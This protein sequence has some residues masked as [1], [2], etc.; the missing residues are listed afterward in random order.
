MRLLVI[1]LLYACSTASVDT[2]PASAQ[3]EAAASP[4]R[5]KAL[6][7]DGW[8]A[9]DNALQTNCRIWPT[10]DDKYICLPSSASQ[11]Q[12]FVDGNCTQPVLAVGVNSCSRNPEFVYAFTSVLNEYPH[13]IYWRG[14]VSVW[15]PDMVIPQPA[16]LFISN[17][18]NCRKSSINAPIAA[19]FYAL[20]AA[21]TNNLVKLTE[22]LEH[23]DNDKIRRPVISDGKTEFRDQYWMTGL[24]TAL[25]EKVDFKNDTWLPRA[26][27]VE[28]L[29]TDASCTTTTPVT[30][31]TEFVYYQTDE[32]YFRGALGETVSTYEGD[33]DACEA[34]GDYASVKLG[35]RLTLQKATPINAGF[36]AVRERHMI[37]DG[38]DFFYGYVTGSNKECSFVTLSDGKE[39]CVGNWVQARLGFSDAACTRPAAL[40]FAYETELNAD[41]LVT[42]T[43][44]PCQKERDVYRIGPVVEGRAYNIGVFG[45]CVAQGTLSG[46]EPAYIPHALELLSPSDFPMRD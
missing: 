16:E 21:N 7:R 41:S 40:V 2:D 27:W 10:S 37:T 26:A 46:G 14:G 3:N 35:E 23:S 8:E 31:E 24:D 20:K 28:Q 12:Y 11:A 44:V 45:D 38:L 39:H 13:T 9:F 25:N 5:L 33:G 22:K 15:T 6:S 43:N 36:G 19:T 17:S 30:R 18:G 34:R 29:N 32:G 1:A 4:P 42:G